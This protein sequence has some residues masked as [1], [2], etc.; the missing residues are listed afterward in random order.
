MSQGKDLKN[1]EDVF[2]IAL[3]PDFL[4]SL[5]LILGSPVI[6]VLSFF[7]ETSGIFKFCATGIMIFAVM[8]GIWEFR[9]LVKIVKSILMSRVDFYPVFCYSRHINNMNKKIFLSGGGTLGSVM[10]LLAIWEKLKDDYNCYWIGSCNGL[11]KEF[12]KKRGIAYLGIP[13]GKIRKY[14]SIKNLLT[15]FLVFLGLK[16]SLWHCV[17][18]RP[19]LI[20]VSGSFVSVPLVWAGWI[21][22]IPIIVHQED[23]NI[24]LAGKLTIPFA[25]FITT[26]FE[27]TTK[28][29][30]RKNTLWIGNPVRNIFY[31]VDRAE[32]EKKWKTKNLPLILVLGGGLGSLRLNDIMVSFARKQEG[33]CTVINITGKG[34]ADKDNFL[35]Y[36]QIEQMDNDIAE[37]IAAADIVVSRAG[38]SSLSEFV[39]LGKVSI[40]V[41]L[42]GVGQNENARFFE[43]RK[44]A[45]LSNE[46]NLETTIIELLKDLERQI[47]LEKNIKTIFPPNSQ[48]SFLKVIKQTIKK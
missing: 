12:V 42:K 45:L 14:L 32:A 9:G 6:F 46:D 25:S 16:S 17:I 43:E 30:N 35:N 29:I 44:A 15:P 40:L 10:P 3:I 48:E 21:L 18:I 7:I 33:I 22:R 13:S 5:Y 34:K 37:V 28:K 1:S 20:I 4:A 41:P 24:G 39:I 8:A 2:L 19:Q 36:K 26:A 31:T 23:I 47:E 11:E 27:I 38:L